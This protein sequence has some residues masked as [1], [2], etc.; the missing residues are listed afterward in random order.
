LLNSIMKQLV[1]LEVNGDVH[2][3]AVSPDTTL[4]KVLRDELGYVGPKRGCDSGGC[5]C[6]T[7]HLGGKAVYSCMVYVMAV[8]GRKVTTVEGLGNGEQL[9]PLQQAFVDAGAVQCG[10]CTSGMIMAAKQLLDET[11]AVDQEQIRK[12]ISGNLCRCTGYTKIVDAVKMASGSQGG[13]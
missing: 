1:Q 11:A 9:D 13:A 4:L 7:V 3:I 6:C 10:Y 2:E 5:G 12:A 8:A